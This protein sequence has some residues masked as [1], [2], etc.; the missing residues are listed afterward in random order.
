MAW[1]N[2]P[3]DFKDCI[4]KAFTKGKNGAD[5]LDSKTRANLCR[6]GVGRKAKIIELF[7]I[8]DYKEFFDIG[9]RQKDYEIVISRCFKEDWTQLQWTFE[10][11][12]TDGD[13]ALQRLYP[14][15]VKVTYRSYAQ[16]GPII[17]LRDRAEFHIDLAKVAQTAEEGNYI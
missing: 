15:K 8:P 7:V 10:R 12:E 14:N 6:L 11:I 2:S 16:E 9:V 3:D 17:E 1:I 4:L 5:Q 13:E